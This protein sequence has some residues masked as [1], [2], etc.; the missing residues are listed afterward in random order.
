[1]AIAYVKKEDLKLNFVN[2]FA[3]TEML[4]G[5]YD[6]PPVRNFRGV[7]KAGC[8]ATPEI[9]ENCLQVICLTDGRGYVTTEDKV[10]TVDELS[11]FTP[12]FNTPYTIHALT[13]MTFTMFVIEMWEKDWKVYNH[14][15]LVLPFFRRV[16][17]SEEYWQDCKTPGTR[18]WSIINGKQMYPIICGVVQSGEG[19]TIEKG[20]PSVAQWNVILEDTDLDLTIAG[21]GTIEQ[22]GGDFSYVPAGPDHS[23]VARPGQHLKYIWFEY[24]V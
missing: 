11:F 24:F 6:Y 18:S 4:A 10:W 17:D 21:E 3:M 2:G 5:A 8:E 9:F 15:Y 12:N 7:I 16:S 13:E 19:G 22:K 23:L 1:M 20:H 14:S